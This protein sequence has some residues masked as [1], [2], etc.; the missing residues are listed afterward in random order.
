VAQSD[1]AP[2]FKLLSRRIDMK[3]ILAFVAAIL[4]LSGVPD[5][6]K[7]QT[8]KSKPAASRSS[9]KSTKR[10]AKV[11]APPPSPIGTTPSGLIYVITRR[12]EGRQPVAGETVFVHYTGMFT[13]GV[14]FD[15]S[16]DKGRPYAFQ[17][18]AGR[19]IKGWDEGIAKLHV[20]D[21]AALVI[22]SSLGYGTSGRG[23]IPPDST[24]VFI[25]ELVGIQEKPPSD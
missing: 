11:V 3:F 2:V 15:S 12:G 25:V 8:R 4:F 23:P 18:G 24:L 1:D 13:S 7:S 20:G 17:L 19:V 16:L 21:Q 22:P 14:K 6:A 10:P 5:T 9:R